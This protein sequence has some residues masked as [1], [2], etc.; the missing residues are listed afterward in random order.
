FDLSRRK[1]LAGLGTIGV[2]GAGAGAGTMALFSDEETFD[3]NQLTAGQ[4]D[5]AVEAEVYEYQGQANTGNRTFSGVQNGQSPTVRQ[6]LSDVKPGD[7]SYGKFCFSLVD[8][9]AYIWNGGELV[10]DS[11]NGSPEPETESSPNGELADAIQVTLY[12]VNSD[13]DETSQGRPSQNSSIPSPGDSR[14]I[15]EGT[16][17]EVLLQLR[18]GLPL[19]ANMSADQAAFAG[20]SSQSAGFD[21]GDNCVAFAWEVP[22]SVGNEIQTDS[23]TFDVAFA[24]QQAR[25]N[26]NPTNPFADAVLTSDATGGIRETDNWITA[27]VSAGPTTVI[28]VD[29]DGAV[30]G[31]D[32]SVNQEVGDQPQGAA[33]LPEWPSNENV[34]FLEANLDIDDDGIDEAANDDDFR[35]G[36]AAAQSG[37][38]ANAI[39]NSTAGASGAGGY[40][41]RNTGGSNAGDP[42]NRTD[43]AEEDVPGF[44]ATESA[45]QLSYTLVLD[46]SA[47]A[48]DSTGDTAELSSVPSAIQINEVFAG[49][50]GEGVGASETT[51]DDGRESVDNVTG[52]SG[53][54][55]I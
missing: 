25:N 14:H 41:R 3:N 11:E 26:P 51:S 8:N 23:V 49:D 22:K 46:W 39:T 12:Y 5:L 35:V 42:A 55:S 6:S 9:P 50:G 36:Y 54:L 29:L 21:N 37:A 17:R 2:A 40:I 18:T 48:G 15:T 53:T 19:T 33:D 32:D 27:R 20:S 1:I 47:I 45:D 44:T 30:Y 24:A 4:L 10:S 38:R 16:L 34:Y 31:N 28:D 43:V 13:Y 7:Y 52:G